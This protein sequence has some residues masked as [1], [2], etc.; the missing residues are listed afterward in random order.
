MVL[1]SKCKPSLCVVDTEIKSY[2]TRFSGNLVLKVTILWTNG[3]DRRQTNFCCSFPL[4]RALHPG[5]IHL[6]AF[7]FFL[8]KVNTLF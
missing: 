7:D 2:Y 6:S 8:L 4:T 3:A 1:V 5:Q